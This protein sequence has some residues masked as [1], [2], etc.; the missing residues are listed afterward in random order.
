MHRTT[1]ILIAAG[2][3]GAAGSIAKPPPQ[4]HA[5]A[6]HRYTIHA[7]FVLGHVGMPASAM[8]CI[9]NAVFHPGQQIV[10]RA[11]FY[12]ASTNK[13]L[14]PAQSLK[15]GL[16]ANVVFSDGTKVVMAD[17]PHP[18]QAKKQAFYWV[19]S[20]IVAPTYPAG[21]LSWTISLRDASGGS[22]SFAP[23]GQDVGIPSIIIVPTGKGKAPA[24]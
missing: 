1:R 11:K 12:D 7:D 14:T 17:I 20:W 9:A 21:P 2:L 19:G 5:A 3:L 10:W 24:H 22:A 23:I 8:S 13:E 6:M 18:P 16:A 4:V 15:L